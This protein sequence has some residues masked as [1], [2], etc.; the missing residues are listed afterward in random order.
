MGMGGTMLS[1]PRFLST[2][3]GQGGKEIMND[4]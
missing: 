4:E 1:I 2:S 3:G